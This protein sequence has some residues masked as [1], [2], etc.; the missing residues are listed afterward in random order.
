MNRHRQDTNVLLIP[1]AEFLGNQFRSFTEQV[2]RGDRTWGEK[3]AYSLFWR[4]SPNTCFYTNDSQHPRD[5]ATQYRG[6]G[7]DARFESTPVQ[8]FL[9]HKYLL[10][11]DGM[12]SAWSGLY[13]KLYSNSLVVKLE[14]HWEQWYYPRL[15]HGHNIWSSDRNLTGTYQDLRAASDSYLQTIAENGR[16]LA[17]SLTYDYA[18]QEYNIA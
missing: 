10:D 9:R 3:D 2:D 12:V 11:L 14:S 1:D 6:L 16:K 17:Q 4:G 13:W 7:V 8:E 5:Y 15:Q 18:V